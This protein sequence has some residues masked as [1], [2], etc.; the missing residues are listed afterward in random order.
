M[1]PRLEQ[2]L[3]E[4]NLADQTLKVVPLTGDASDRRYFRLL[5]KDSKSIVLALH[6]GPIEYHA[7]PFVAVAKLLSEV[8]VPVPRILY[9]SDPLGVLALEDLGDVTLQAHLGAATPSEHAALYRQAVTFIARMQQRG[10]ALRSDAYPPYRIAFDVEKLTWEL[11]FFVKHYLLGY[12]GLA[13]T[14]AQRDALRAEWA[15][16][17]GE[18]SSERRV[19]CHRDYHSRNLMLHDG[20]LYIIDF[21]DARMGPDT[22]DLV[23]LLRDSYVDLAPPHVDELIAFFLAVKGVAD[24]AEFRRR[25]DLMA[26]QRNLKALGTFGYMTTSRNNTVYI[27]Y[28]PRTVAYVKANLAKYPR[29][30]RLQSL[31][32]PWL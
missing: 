24:E 1:E 3:A 13:P 8:P 19:L 22:Y 20:S 26:L 9:H 32:D 18:L 6:A 25:F 23:S 16:I 4:Q 30:E 14:E 29:F 7:M 12:K 2:F 28:I 31:L 15:A 10:D 21:Q 11:E 5:L 17:V 27:Q